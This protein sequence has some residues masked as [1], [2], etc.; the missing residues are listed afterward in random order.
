MP[1]AVHA[2]SM[3][4]LVHEALLGASVDR[5]VL[6]TAELVRHLLRSRFARVGLRAAS[7]LVGTAGDAFL[8]LLEGGLGGVG[9][10]SSGVSGWSLVG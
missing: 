9:S 6:A 1:V 4:R 2:E 5:L 3:L 10:L 7:D 8:G